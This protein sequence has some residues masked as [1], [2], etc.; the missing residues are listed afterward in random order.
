M[1]R[2]GIDRSTVK[3]FLFIA[4]ATLLVYSN[5]FD[6]SWH[7]DDYDN[8]LENPGIHL[9]DLYPASIVKSL[10]ASVNGGEYKGD[11]LYR[12]VAM[13]SFA[14]NWYAGQDQVFGYHLVNV[15]IHVMTG[16]L[17]FLTINAL[18]KAPNINFGDPIQRYHIALLSALI[19]AVHPI[20]VSCVTYIVQRMALLAAFFYIAGLFVYC[21]F[22]TVKNPLK[23]TGLFFLYWSMFALGMGSKENTILM[24]LS[25]LLLEITFYRKS[26]LKTLLKPKILISV[27]FVA[28]ILM[29][30]VLL[31]TQGDMGKFLI[32]FDKRPFTP[33]ERL[34]TQSRVIWMYIYQMIYPVSSQYS[35]E[36]DIL[37]STSLFTPWTTL[38]AITGIL[39]LVSLSMAK[40]NRYPVLSFSILFFFLNHM[41]ESTILNLELV[42]EHRNYLP[43]MFLSLPLVL[44]GQ[45]ALTGYQKQNPK[46]FIRVLLFIVFPL[47]LVAVAMGTYIRNMDW[48]T[49][50]A[51]WE[52]AL[53]KAPQ[54]SRPYQA[55]AVEYYQP[56]Q[57]WDKAIELHIKAIALRDSK[58]AFMRMVGYDNL[59]FIHQ[60]KGDH[61][62]ALEYAQKAV[63]E[64]NG[65]HI[66]YNYIEALVFA[67]DIERAEQ[68]INQYV[69]DGPPK[70]KGLNLKTI[71]LLKLEKYGAAYENA[72]KAMQQDPLN[73]DAIL[74]FGYACLVT[75]HHDKA[76]HYLKKALKLQPA[77]ELF[78]R[79]CLL[80]NS[81][82]QKDKAAIASSADDL[83]KAYPPS[84]MQDFLTDMEKKAYPVIPID[85][86]VMAGCI[87]Q[88]MTEKIIRL[89]QP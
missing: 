21:Q 6:A 51:L 42:F 30:A 64:K 23:K 73:Q 29:C 77:H 15:L 66:V 76:A 53:E 38:P 44:G 82:N 5:S 63:N 80:Q 46:T 11:T 1:E 52:D 55:L 68:S 47:I 88:R 13:L 56:R 2:V 35:V 62:T 8:I 54:R 26:S 17:L 78:I 37:I 14:L 72:R 34:M 48:K 33:L 61:K 41:V 86:K 84:L 24:P 3:G 79:L 67:N 16:F 43:S 28:G 58:P 36:H 19:W 45:K 85:V 20:Q 83:I 22:R 60:Q 74:Y 65:V 10:Y 18:L 27:C 75:H 25:T 12:P 9:T 32:G 59:R 71:I 81:L 50:K 4:F 49:E 57:D 39:T 31:W 70:I 87:N 40:L 89:H 7:L 69:E